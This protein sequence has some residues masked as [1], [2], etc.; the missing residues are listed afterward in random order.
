MATQSMSDS[1]LLSAAMM[2]ARFSR[3]YFASGFASLVR[4]FEPVK[5]M[6][7]TDSGVLVVDPAFLRNQPT[8][9]VGE[10]LTHELLHLLRRHPARAKA[11]PGVDRMKWSIS[12]DL[13]I[14]DDL[15][16]DLLPDGALFPARFNLAAGL[17]AEEYYANAMEQEQ[18]RQQ[19]QK[20][21]DKQKGEKKEE[22]KAEPNDQGDEESDDAEQPKEGGEGE[23][24]G[25]G[26]GDQQGEGSG[27][28]EGEGEGEG[29]GSGVGDGGGEADVA[30]GRC[31]SGSGGE[32][33]PG[34]ENWKGKAKG[35]SES[36]L[37]R[38]RRQV[39]SDIV[40]ASKGRGTVPDGFLRMAEK[41]L[42][43]PKIR[44]E[45]KLRRAI[46]TNVAFA[47]GKVDYS[48][49]RPNRRQSQFATAARMLGGRSPI[50]PS[51]VAPLPTVAIGIDTSGSMGS[52][53]LARAVSESQAVMRTLAAPVTFLACDSECTTPTKVRT[54]RDLLKNLKGGGGTDFRPIFDAVTA[55]RPMPSVFVFV[56]DGM[57]PAP[58]AAPKGYETIWVLVGKY[59][60]APVEWGTQIK[61]TE[62][63]E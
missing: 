4:R 35:R 45:T 56:T 5:T 3:P 34:E 44:W 2:A 40:E 43:P 54:W 50:L 39:A 37:D 29:G 20:G 21:G 59:A 61:V 55:L 57:G 62:D 13:E 36:D 11:I 63:S 18:R 41:E 38:M 9:V 30:K 12:A 23:G 26:E 58:E 22:E 19:K 15:R 46:R 49:T 28:G 31:G 42:K 60:H 51:L 47:A 14:N 17:T 32:P 53:E 33:L 24:Q 7:V 52:S 27:E 16:A 25:D 10:C 6:V 48:R 1:D 8:K